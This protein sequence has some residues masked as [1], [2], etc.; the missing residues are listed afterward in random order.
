[1]CVFSFFFAFF[2]HKCCISIQAGDPQEV[3]ALSDVFCNGRSSPLLMGSVKSNM[4]HAEPASGL[5]SIVKV[6]VTIAFRLYTL[7]TFFF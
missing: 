4:G 1:M 7:M 6:K 5:C 3:N 2:F